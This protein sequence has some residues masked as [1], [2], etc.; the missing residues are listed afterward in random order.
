M[1]IC[2]IYRRKETGPRLC[3]RSRKMEFTYFRAPFRDQ[4]PPLAVTVQRFI[5]YFVV[6]NIAVT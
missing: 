4:T 1:S 2:C 6:G 3:L 5:G